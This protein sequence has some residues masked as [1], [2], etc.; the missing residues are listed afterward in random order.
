MIPQTVLQ[1]LDN[2]LGIRA[3]SSAVLAI[4]ATATTGALNTPQPFTRI[5]DVEQEYTDG[6]LVEVAAYAI[7]RY[8]LAVL[9]VRA[10]ASNPGAYGPLTVSFKGTSTPTLDP[11][12]HP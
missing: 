12:T 8:G 10:G 2:Q 7:E 1:V 5:A 9:T 6:P 4:V 3:P 11:T